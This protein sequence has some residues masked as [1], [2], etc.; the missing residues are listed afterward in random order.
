MRSLRQRAVAGGAIWATVVVLA[1]TNAVGNY[2]EDL[3]LSR[4]DEQLAARHTQAVVALANTGGASEAMRD[5]L[6]DPVYQRP[7]SGNYWQATNEDGGIVVSRSLADSLLPVGTSPATNPVITGI[8][9]PAG[10]NLRALSRQMTLDDGAV[11]LVTVASSTEALEADQ[12]G[13]RQRLNVSFALVG[14]LAVA[15][16]FLL[17]IFTLRPLSQLRKDVIARKDHEGQLPVESYPQEVQALVND[18]NMLLDRNREIVSRSRRQTVDLAHALKTPSAVLRNELFEMQQAGLQVQK[19]IH[20][21]DR[22]DAQLKRSFARMKATQ[23]S[24]L[25]GSSTD[26]N[27][28]L[29]RLGRAFTALAKRTGREVI[30]NVPPDLHAKINQIDFEEIIGNL[31]DN[32]LKWSV[33]VIQLTADATPDLVRII[34][35]DDGP[36][37]AE[38]GGDLAFVSGQRLDESKPG[39]G[40]GLAIA[41][42]LVIAYQGAIEVQRSVQLDG[43]RLV[44][45]LRRDAGSD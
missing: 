21:L 36:G 15:G 29:A 12:A 8:E 17:V 41:S 39:T 37:M 26:L 32:A 1:G 44:V 43:A 4:F 28:S 9:G 25:E 10:Q 14:L 3:T 6:N 2:L 40:L 30:I 33:N 5:Q 19:G 23:D 16:A 34:V 27:V 35:E 42:D 18:I 22:L 20:A 11:W 31:L 24:A 45:T 13:L 7:F 38:G